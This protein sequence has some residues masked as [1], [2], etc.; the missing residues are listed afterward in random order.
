MYPTSLVRV[1]DPLPPYVNPSTTPLHVPSPCDLIRCMGFFVST[2]PNPKPN[3][4]PIALPIAELP[5]PRSGLGHEINPRFTLPALHPLKIERTNDGWIA[6]TGTDLDRFITMRLEQP[7][8]GPPVAVLSHGGAGGGR[9]RK[10]LFI[11]PSA[12]AKQRLCV[13]GSWPFSL[14]H[15]CSVS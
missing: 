10:G 14:W 6:L 12:A 3:V 15:P 11:D 9:D 13:P 1:G 7:A 8:E 2:A 4:H 5:P